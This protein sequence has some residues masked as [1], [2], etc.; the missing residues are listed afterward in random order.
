VT[1]TDKLAG[2]VAVVTGG[3]SGLGAVM[4]RTFAEVGKAVT[5]LA[6]SEALLQS[7][8]TV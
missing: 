7:G 8:A 4:E 3:G 1:N 2:R 5:T 6:T